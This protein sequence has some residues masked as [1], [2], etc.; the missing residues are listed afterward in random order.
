MAFNKHGKTEIGT[1]LMWVLII[2]AIA[3][4]ADFGGFQDTINN[5]LGSTQ[6]SPVPGAQAP[7]GLISATDCPTDGTTTYTINV[8]DALATT[9]TSR[10][11]E[12]YIFNGNQL[13]KEG[14]LSSTASTVSLSCGKDYQLL[15]VNTTAGNGATHYP[16]IIDLKA[17]VAQ[18]TVNTEIMLAGD[19][20]IYKIINPLEGASSTYYNN[21]SIGVSTTKSWEIQ[22][23]ANHT[24]RAINK[25]IILCDVNVSEILTISLDSFDDGKKPVVV[26]VP[27]RI[28]ATTG[29]MYYAWEYPGILEPADGVITGKGSITTTSSF[30]T[31]TNAQN[32]TCK[33]ADQAMWKKSNYKTATSIAD[34]FVTG[35]EN[36]ET[37]ADVGTRDSSTAQ[38]FFVNDNGV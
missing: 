7:S 17:R 34:G 27:K 8:Q 31:G 35:P 22:F 36:T 21:M 11:P 6:V 19:S 28:T 12:Y 4:V 15:L 24:A 26:N 3:Y 1:V 13:I 10:Y 9:A 2:G 16:V 38:M 5:M 14:T 20:K 30:P 25:P 37:L 29:R 33:L 18:Q 23:G 32:M